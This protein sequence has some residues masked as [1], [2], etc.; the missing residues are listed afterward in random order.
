[1]QKKHLKIGYFGGHESELPDFGTSRVR[2]D[3]KNTFQA[4]VVPATGDCCLRYG[5]QAH[6]INLKVTF[7]GHPVSILTPDIHKYHLPFFSK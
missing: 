7:L 5:A 6:S 1:M 2:N 3:R 4:Q